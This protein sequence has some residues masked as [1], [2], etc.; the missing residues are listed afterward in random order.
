M[1]LALGI[2]EQIKQI[3][4]LRIEFQIVPLSSCQPNL[5]DVPVC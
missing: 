1:A 2:R 3:I 4:H 5:E